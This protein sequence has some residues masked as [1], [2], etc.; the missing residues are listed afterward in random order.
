M[1]QLADLREE[2]DFLT[3]ENTRLRQEI[4]ESNSKK[5]EENNSL[6]KAEKSVQMDITPFEKAKELKERHI[7]EYP[8]IMEE[9]NKTF[10]DK[11]MLLTEAEKKQL[12]PEQMIGMSFPCDGQQ[13][14]TFFNKGDS[15]EIE[16]SLDTATDKISVKI[17]GD[18]TITFMTSALVEGGETEGETWKLIANNDLTLIAQDNWENKVLDTLAISKETGLGIWQ[19]TEASGFPMTFRVPNGLMIYLQ[20]YLP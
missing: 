20:C 10:P 3:E 13:V 7:Y 2:N 16:G 6:A 11:E 12:F 5:S 8:E 15:L 14:A 1:Q 9:L 4:E 18:D 19:K 17:N